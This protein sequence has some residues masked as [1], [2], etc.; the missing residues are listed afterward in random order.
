MTLASAFAFLL[1]S[2]RFCLPSGFHTTSAQTY[3]GVPMTVLGQRLA[4]EIHTPSVNLF[5]V[6]GRMGC[7]HRT[8]PKHPLFADVFVPV[9]TP[10]P[11]TAGCSWFSDLEPVPA[12]L[13]QEIW[14]RSQLGMRLVIAA[15]RST[16]PLSPRPSLTLSGE[17]T[18]QT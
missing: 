1:C 11:L 5:E 13:Y 6:H 12:S 9:A 4:D 16:C 7:R 15:F 18:T 3:D 10:I 14:Q 8:F 17:R 2:Q